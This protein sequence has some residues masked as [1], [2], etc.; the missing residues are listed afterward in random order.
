MRAVRNAMVAP[1]KM[2]EKAIS[3]GLVRSGVIDTLV[4]VG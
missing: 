4:V 2:E 1:M 3:R